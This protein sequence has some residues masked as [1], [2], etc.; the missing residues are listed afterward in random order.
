RGPTRRPSRDH[1]GRYAL[2][3]PS[4]NRSTGP[5]HCSSQSNTG[6]TYRLEYGEYGEYDGRRI[7]GFDH[8]MGAVLIASADATNESARVTVLTEWQLSPHQFVCPW[9]SQDPK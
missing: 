4:R 9:D 2:R 1:A 5:E 7:D 6:R 3:V 8:D